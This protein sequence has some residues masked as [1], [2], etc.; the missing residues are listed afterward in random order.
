[1]M[2]RILAALLVLVMMFSVVGC[3]N[4]NQN[5]E[6]SND[7]GNVNDGDGTNNGENN[8]TSIQEFEDV[9]YTPVTE[10]LLG[11]AMWNLTEEPYPYVENQAIVIDNS[12]YSTMWKFYYVEH[13]SDG[14]STTKWGQYDV[15][16]GENNEVIVNYSSEATLVLGYIYMIDN[17]ATIVATH[18]VVDYD[19][20]NTATF[21]FTVSSE[22]YSPYNYKF[23]IKHEHSEH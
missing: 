10:G 14:Y 3:G 16:Y 6:N 23:V 17:K 1:M 9:D 11:I 5:G 4:T 21:D 8:G 12:I 13:C 18:D 22:G 7:V 19:E 2:A 20:T 15:T